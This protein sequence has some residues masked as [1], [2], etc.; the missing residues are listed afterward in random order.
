L[1]FSPH[2]IADFHPLWGDPLMGMIE[3][4][5]PFFSDG[6]AANPWYDSDPPFPSIQGS[7]MDIADNSCLFHN[8]GG[9]PH[10]TLWAAP[11]PS[12]LGVLPANTWVM[13]GHLNSP[14]AFLP[15]GPN[16]TRLLLTWA[17]GQFGPFGTCS[18]T[19]RQFGTYAFNTAPAGCPDT[20][21]QLP[22]EGGL[23]RRY[24]REL[25]LPAGT[26]RNL[27]TFLAVYPAYMPGG[28]VQQDPSSG[29]AE[30]NARLRS[31][32]EGR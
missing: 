17:T 25:N 21:P 23:G 14:G 9:S 32:T 4:A 24:N 28:G 22:G 13:D 10:V 30:M 8:K 7:A 27:Q 20:L 16:G 5:T 11:P 31:A 26:P 15:A 18:G 19:D 3:T 6:Y 1:D 29:P 12:G 2:L